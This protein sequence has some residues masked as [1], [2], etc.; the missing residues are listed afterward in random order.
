MELI[1]TRKEKLQVFLL[2]S[3]A[4]T[5]FGGGENGWKEERDG[6]MLR[7][8]LGCCIGVE[9]SWFGARI[10]W[11]SDGWDDSQ[12][13][14]AEHEPL[15]LFSLF[16][17]C[18]HCIRLLKSDALAAASNAGTEG[19]FPSVPLAGGEWSSKGGSPFLGFPWPVLAPFTP[20]LIFD[21]SV[22]V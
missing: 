6:E 20:V 9:R 22:V 17:S 15:S 1:I 21:H 18:P 19:I 2:T 14:L 11:K 16:F 7:F 10:Q 13:A 5:R 4:E 8:L 3:C 12:A